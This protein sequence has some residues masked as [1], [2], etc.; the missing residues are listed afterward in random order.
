MSKTWLLFENKSYY[1]VNCSL[2]KAPKSHPKPVDAYLVTE[3]EGDFTIAARKAAHTVFTCAQKR[4]WD[5]DPVVAGFDLSERTRLDTSIAGQSGG[6]GFALSFAK[7]LLHTDPGNIAATGVIEANGKIGRVN[8]IE[9]KLETA[10]DL[11][12]E[13]GIILFPKKNIPDISQNL[14]TLL[15]QE[16]I[17]AFPV[18]DMDQ[19]FDILFK[20]EAPACKKSFVN[21]RLL[22]AVLIL[23]AGAIAMA[24]WVY[25]LDDNKTT[26]PPTLKPAI[27]EPEI[28]EPIAQEPVALKKENQIISMDTKETEKPKTEPLPDPEPLL[29]DKSSPLPEDNSKSPTD[30]AK[31]RPV[32]DKGFE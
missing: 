12:R 29:T 1:S 8:G 2:H 28:Q 11:T 5:L 4:G 14:K 19:V 16:H 20:K 10:L 21:K 25:F 23:A 3:H 15:K 32:D 27:L 31:S 13:Q 26:A 30:S 7:K 24:S 17:K 9:A 6:L 18:A 22:S